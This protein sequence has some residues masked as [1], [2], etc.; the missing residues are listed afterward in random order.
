M[1]FLELEV[2]LKRCSSRCLTIHTLFLIA[3]VRHRCSPDIVSEDI[4]ENAAEVL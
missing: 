4:A 1:L 3:S 2:V